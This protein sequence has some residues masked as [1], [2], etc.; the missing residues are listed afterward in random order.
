[1]MDKYGI[2]LKVFADII[3][4][5]GR[6]TNTYASENKNKPQ[7]CLTKGEFIKFLGLLLLLGINTRKYERE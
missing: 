6:G 1:M 4:L 5:T 7:F 3:G 2:F